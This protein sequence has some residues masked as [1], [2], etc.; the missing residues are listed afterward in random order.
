[1]KVLFLKNHPKGVFKGEVK[2]MD[3]EY[4]KKYLI[5]DG[6]AEEVKEKSESSHSQDFNKKIYKKRNN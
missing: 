4:C 5:P 6:Y 1:M 2:D 3:T